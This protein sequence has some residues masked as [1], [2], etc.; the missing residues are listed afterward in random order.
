MLARRP[1]DDAGVRVG[2]LPDG[3]HVRAVRGVAAVSRTFRSPWSP[4]GSASTSNR[5][6]PLPASRAS[7][8]ITNEQAWG[9]DD[10]PSGMRFVS[11]HRECIGC[12]TC[13]MQAVLDAPSERTAP[14]RSSARDRPI[15][16]ARCTPTSRSPSSSWSPTANATACRTSPWNGFD[17]IRTWLESDSALPGPVAPVRCP[18]WTLP[19]DL[20]ELPEG[21]T[22]RS[23]TL[24]DVDIVTGSG[25]GVRAPP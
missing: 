2:A 22:A 16:T 23:M 15:G 19:V 17:D 12:G 7:G 5:C 20:T 4:T 14:W 18:G 21:L 8:I 6:W 13:K 9:P 25:R 24:T 11:G 1:R 10:R 3:S